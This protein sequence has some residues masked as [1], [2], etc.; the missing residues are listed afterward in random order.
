[1]LAYY[2][3]QIISL[4]HKIN[5]LKSNPNDL[6]LLKKI[7]LILLD[8][9]IYSEKK[10]SVHKSRI[11]DFKKLLRQKGN[12]KDTAVKIKKKINFLN[13]RVQQGRW[14]IYVWKAFG[15]ALAYI[16]IDK[17]NLKPL[18]YNVDNTNMKESS[19]YFEKRG[20]KNELIYL[21]EALSHGV[22]AI[23]NDLTNSIRYGDV[24]LL[25]SNIPFLIEIKSSRNINSRFQRQ[26]Q[27]LDILQQYLHTDYVENYRGMPNCTR[28]GMPL[29]EVS[30]L[31]TI[32]SLMGKS[33]DKGWAYTSPE[34][35]VVYFVSHGQATTHEVLDEVFAGISHPQIFFVN[36]AKTESLWMCYY[37]FTLAIDEPEHLYAFLKGDLTI[38]VVVDLAKLR[39][40]AIELN[41]ELIMLGDNEEYGWEVLL[42]VQG[43]TEKIQY[44][45]SHHM[46]ER[47]AYEFI[48]PR[49]LLENSNALAIKALEENILENTE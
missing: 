5:S 20:L 42:S 8:K 28:F 46:I 19:G 4:K 11:G 15:D 16:Y 39:E 2:K 37:P 6:V 40:I 27:G 21:N 7:Q 36:S 31:E 38:V 29:T 35:G 13:M 24:C 41:G 44:R 30:Y 32:N 12:S 10:I 18:L 34:K 17:W 23:L 25:G 49:W 45:I 47:I 1:M 9:I 3:N 33:K 48:S 26:I 14:L 43:Y 22:P